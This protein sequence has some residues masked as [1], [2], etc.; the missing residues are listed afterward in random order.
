MV[1]RAHTRTFQ[2]DVAPVSRHGVKLCHIVQKQQGLDACGCSTAAAALEHSMMQ[3]EACSARTGKHLFGS[4][5]QGACQQCMSAIEFC[6]PQALLIRERMGRMHTGL[7]AMTQRMRPCAERTCMQCTAY[8]K[9]A[10][11]VQYMNLHVSVCAPARSQH[12]RAQ[13]CGHERARRAPGRVLHRGDVL[14]GGRAARAGGGAAPGVPQQAAQ[15]QVG[16]GA[17]ACLMAVVLEASRPCLLTLICGPA[18][19]PSIV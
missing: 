7:A 6:L 1:R 12:G 13:G 10:G 15:P 19:V 14:Q 5:G 2:D 9:K 17:P 4:S 16:A 11:Q 18:C 8:V 3:Q